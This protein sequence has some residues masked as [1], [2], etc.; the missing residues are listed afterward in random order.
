MTVV[1]LGSQVVLTFRALGPVAM[2]DVV[3]YAGF[4]ASWMQLA[5]RICAIAC[6]LSRLPDYL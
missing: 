5:T 1:R 6:I 2:P 4:T 3:S